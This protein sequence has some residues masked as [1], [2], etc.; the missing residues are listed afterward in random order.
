M[1]GPNEG[2]RD[3]APRLVVVIS[4][5]GRNL[6]AI[7]RAIETGDLNAQ[8][9]LVISNRSDAPGMQI[10]RLAGLNCVCIE[11]KGF[12]RRDDFD[13]ALGARIAAARPDWVVL[14]GYMR[15][16]SS[17]FVQRFE[18]KL[19]NIHPS[20]LPRYKGLNTHERALSNGDAR[21]GAS[22]HFV[23][24]DL[25]DGPLI[26]Q[27]SIA[28]A[29]DDTPETL[30]DRLMAD[31]EQRL[32]PAALAELIAGTVRFYDGVVWRDGQIQEQCP[33]DDYDS[34]ATT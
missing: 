10:A 21:H 19:V 7:I 13:R 30:A 20:L 17:A 12:K 2:A 34:I 1:I 6:Q 32:Y 18:S 16:L 23:T 33:H 24:P 28:I 26:R 22:V 9:A 27:A 31:V 14:A 29:H 11:P 15:I 3:T 5:R 25:D 8:I 4:G